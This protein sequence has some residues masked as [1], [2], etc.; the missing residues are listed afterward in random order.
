V[1]RKCPACLPFNDRDPSA[2]SFTCHSPTSPLSYPS[3]YTNIFSRSTHWPSLNSFVT[4]TLPPIQFFHPFS[5]TPLAYTSPG[6]N[7]SQYPSAQPQLFHSCPLP[8]IQFFNNSHISRPRPLSK[9]R[10]PP[11]LVRALRL[12]C[13]L[14]ATTTTTVTIT[15]LR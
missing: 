11:G 4:A 8:P 3:S 14:R 12:P 15:S 13:R 2:L 9:V 1:P 5:L 6:I 7:R 10:Y